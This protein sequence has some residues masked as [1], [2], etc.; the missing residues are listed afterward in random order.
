MDRPLSRGHDAE[1]NLNGSRLDDGPEGLV[2]VDA[3]ALGE[4]ADDSASL[5]ASQGAIRVELMPEDPLAGDHVGDG[6]TG[7]KAPGG[8]VDE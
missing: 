4:A 5:V 1:D 6:R 2:V 3:V 8:V 7:N